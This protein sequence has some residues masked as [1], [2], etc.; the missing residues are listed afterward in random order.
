MC[1]KYE[2]LKILYYAVS[3]QT[4]ARTEISPLSVTT[5][6]VH[7]RIFHTPHIILNFKLLN[8]VMRVKRNSNWYRS[9]AV[10]FGNFVITVFTLNVILFEIFLCHLFCLL[11]LSQQLHIL[12]P[13]FLTQS[14]FQMLFPVKFSVF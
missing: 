13:V 4:Q 10:F 6:N 11:R 2:R 1:V 7:S 8:V 14:S 12:W 3:L 5:R 9:T